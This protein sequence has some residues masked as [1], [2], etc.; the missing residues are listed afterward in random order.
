MNI[1]RFEEGLGRVMYVAGALEYER[2]FLAPLYRFMTIH[3][4]GST[5]RLPPYVA[6]F[7]RYLSQQ[8]SASRH[9]QCAVVLL[10][11]TTG[12]RVDAQAS[13][14]RT[15]IGG[16]LPRVSPDG[17][18]DKWNSPWFSHELTSEEWPW[19]FAKSGK[20]AL[21]ISTLEGLATATQSTCGPN[22]DR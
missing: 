1:S 11:E 20:P 16:W 14:S 12:P 2:P 21:F 10:P 4:R 18:P 13:P 15:G 17:V 6:L 22:V 8:V 9:S 5:R 19:V 7:L 3:P